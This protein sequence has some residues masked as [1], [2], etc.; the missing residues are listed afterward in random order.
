MGSRY[1][2]LRMRKRDVVAK[3]VIILTIYIYLLEM[4][5]VRGRGSVDVIRTA[6]LMH[7]NF[8]NILS[9]SELFIRVGRVKAAVANNAF[10][11]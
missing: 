3:F 1:K 9:I 2:Y 4:R 11:S 10:R 6:L 8:R 5:N 7:P